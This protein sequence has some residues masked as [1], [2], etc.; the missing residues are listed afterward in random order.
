[1]RS[2][3]QQ[4]TEVF[5]L[6]GPPC[7]RLHISRVQG[8]WGSQPVFL[9][10]HQLSSSEGQNHQGTFLADLTPSFKTGKKEEL[11]S[12]SA[13]PCCQVHESQSDWGWAVWL[14]WRRAAHLCLP[15]VVR[16]LALHKDPCHQ[17]R[18]MCI[19]S[20][21]KVAGPMQRDLTGVVS[22]GMGKLWSGWS[23]TPLENAGTWELLLKY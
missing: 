2:C 20:G 9:Q 22:T 1:M 17:I 6:I 13:T 23:Q 4:R 7:S 14:Y 16:C 10:S 19:I 21:G 15:S 11:A 18:E 5:K 3:P 8:C 12:W